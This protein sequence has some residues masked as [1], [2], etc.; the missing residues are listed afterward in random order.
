MTLVGIV[1]L[2]LVIGAI[3]Y[4]ISLLPI[5]VTIKRI[6]YVVVVIVV[7]IYVLQQFGLI[8]GSIPLK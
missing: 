3:L 2:L 7:L 8:S 1:V 5:D 6:I 4:I